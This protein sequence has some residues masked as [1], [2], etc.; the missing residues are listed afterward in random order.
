M[1][2]RRVPI[3]VMR[4]GIERRT[5]GRER[6]SAL[7]MQGH[8]VPRSRVTAEPVSFEWRGAAVLPDDRTGT[9]IV[10]V[11]LV[12]CLFELFCH[13]FPSSILF[14]AFVRSDD[15]ALPTRIRIFVRLRLV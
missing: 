5:G 9:V 15:P 6:L 8:G 2:L 3:S 13:F 4:I 11:Y 7:V 1:C 12:R 10:M 14:F